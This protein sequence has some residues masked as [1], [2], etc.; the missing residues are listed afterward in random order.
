[1]MFSFVNMLLGIIASMPPRVVVGP[2]NRL[3][4]VVWLLELLYKIL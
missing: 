2:A 4:L 1:V 3:W